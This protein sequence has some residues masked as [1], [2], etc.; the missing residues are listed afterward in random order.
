MVNFS[1]EQYLT[2]MGEDIVKV[3]FLN[4]GGV[5]QDVQVILEISGMNLSIIV[6]G[7][8]GENVYTWDLHEF[9]VVLNPNPD[10]M[11]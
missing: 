4:P 6:K 9:N 2:I 11:V 8:H 3:D 5:R 1:K 10:Y 7:S